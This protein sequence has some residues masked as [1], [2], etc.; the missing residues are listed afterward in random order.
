MGAVKGLLSTFDAA[1]NELVSEYQETIFVRNS[2]GYNVGT[3]LFGLMSRL[4][5]EA[6]ENIEYRWFERDPVRK[7]IYSDIVTTSGTT[8]IAFRETSGGANGSGNPYLVAGTVLMANTANAGVTPEWIRLDTVPS[9]STTGALVTVTRALAGT[10]TTYGTGQSWTI[11]TVGKTEGADPTS[12]VYENPNTIANYI[13]TF[14]SV[15][16]ITNAF[17]GSVLRTDIE[18]PLTDRRI[19]ALERISRDIEFSYFLGRAVTAASSSGIYYTGGIYDSI[20]TAG[21]T[22]TNYLSGT[23][24]TGAVTLAAFNNFLQNVMGYGS[25]V[26]LAFC[27]PAAY[28]AISNYANSGTN[29]YRIM[30]NETVFGMNI[31]VINTPF[32]ELNLTQHPLFR[33]AGA[34]STTAETRGLQTWMFIVDLP[35]M[36][37]KVFEKLFLEPNIQSNGTDSYKEQ[38]RAKLGL[39]LKFPNA[40][41]VASNIVSLS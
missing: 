37:Q 39:K 10:A 14:N 5:Q 2:R 11:V 16:E 38:F 7:V 21:I 34:Y 28:A 1:T 4:E 24:S 17:K 12:A 22:S 8:T 3:T 27:G 31:Q 41:G 35:M 26:K 30:Q 33:E 6:A 9:A 32:G 19:Q 25:D 40:F 13:Q 36:V 18:G 29:G 23:T 15:V 20:V